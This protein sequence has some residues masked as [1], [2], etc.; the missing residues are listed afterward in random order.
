MCTM[1]K[2]YRE[3]TNTFLEIFILCMYMHTHTH[4]HTHDQLLN[5]EAEVKRKYLN[6][7]FI[8]PPLALGVASASYTS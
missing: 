3:H 5:S 7:T 8:S 2:D 4:T 1:V 6:F